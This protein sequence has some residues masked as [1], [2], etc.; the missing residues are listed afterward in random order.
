[1]HRPGQGGFTLI[2]LLVALAVMAMMAVLGWRG[3]DAVM[4][5]QARL[6]QRADELQTL[7]S[8]LAQWGADLDAVQTLPRTPAMD[9]DGRGLRLLRRVSEPVESLAVVA[10]ARRDVGVPDGVGG[11]GSL[12]SH[13]LRWQ[14]PPLRTRGDV[15]TA[16]A[17][18]AQWAQNPGDD[19]RAREVRVVPLTQ[20]QIFYF[21]GNAWSNPLSAADAPALGG[22]AS[23]AGGAGATG[24][25][26]AAAG[27]AAG[28]ALVSATAGSATGGDT[29]VPDGVRLVLTLPPGQAI[30]GVLTRDWVR[31]TAGGGK[32]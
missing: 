7:Q 23:A 31:P 19:L 4:Q 10:W 27:V 26:A 30:S 12:A 29:S 22:M 6:G 5:T 2:E 14:S 11:G 16:W 28:A 20:W 17:Q 24:A 25:F 3:L 21:R 15:Q 8:G 18:A 32:L 13:W 1:M 9:W